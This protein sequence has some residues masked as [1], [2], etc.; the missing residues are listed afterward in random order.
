VAK[1]IGRRRAHKDPVSADLR[2]EVI[3]RDIAFAGGCAA[4][5]LDPDHACRNQYGDPQ[6]PGRD[7]TLDHV[8]DEYGRMGKRAPSRRENLV[9][10]CYYAHLGGWA[11]SHRPL[12]RAYLERA[13]RGAA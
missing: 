10:L 9:S 11:T 8:Q 5:F 1:V 3:R 7:L 12:L 4:A 2:I 6:H 13:N